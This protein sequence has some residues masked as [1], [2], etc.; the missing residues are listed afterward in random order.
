MVWRA[1]SPCMECG[2]D[3]RELKMLQDGAHS[4]NEVL[5]FGRFSLVLCDFCQID[6]GTY[7]AYFFGLP[8]NKHLGFN[9]LAYQRMVEP[10]LGQDWVCTGCG[11]RMEFVQAVLGM[12]IALKA[13]E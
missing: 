8:R 6:F 11:Y 5:V 13:V 7:P 3:P 4:Y 10:V 2:G 9:D 12:R 1:V